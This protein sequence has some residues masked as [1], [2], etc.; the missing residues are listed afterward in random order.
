MGARSLVYV[1]DWSLCGT[2]SGCEATQ[3]MVYL[4][5]FVLSLAP[6]AYVRALH[7]SV[8]LH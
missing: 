7:H 5:P 1:R 6:V 3:L 8:H 4:A 2:G